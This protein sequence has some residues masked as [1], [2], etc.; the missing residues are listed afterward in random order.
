MITMK[1]QKITDR[2]LQGEGD[3]M[4]LRQLLI[5]T[6]Q[7]MGRE[8]NWELRR[9]EGSYW[10]ASDDDLAN[11]K[12]GARAH[13]WETADK[14]LIAAAV[15][16]AAG[17]LAIQIHPDYRAIE[18]DILDWAE[19]HVTVIKDDGQRELITWAFEWDTDRQVRLT[20]RGYEPDPKLFW[21]NRRRAI[22]D[23][24]PEL[25]LAD[26]YTIR[27]AYDTDE[28]VQKWVAC[29]NVVFGHKH[30]AAWYR[31]FTRL[32]PSY[33]CDLH[34]LAEAPDGTV[35]AF[36]GLTV[37]EA[38]RYAIFEPVGTHPEHRRKG[39]SR[40]VMYEGIRRLQALDIA[41]V[42]YVASWGTSDAGKFYDSVGLAQY[43]I[44]QGWKRTVQGK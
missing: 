27:S 3:A 30:P 4:R 28:D 13:I 8:F 40:A 24:L 12:W 42:V 25:S 22:S 33:N 23:P 1:S 29:T 20:Q 34:I 43:T 10:Y 9:W 16:E 26:G 19:A 18:D 38:N 14:Q 5:D 6:Y 41:D 32:S 44:T 17:D 21:H 7:M 31:N 39:L 2:R 15:P 36:A 37:D 11:P 35:A